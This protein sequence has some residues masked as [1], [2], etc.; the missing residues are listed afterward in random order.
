MTIIENCTLVICSK[1]LLSQLKSAFLFFIYS[2][3]YN[4]RQ[5]SPKKYNNNSNT[6]DDG[7]VLISIIEKVD[8]Y[9]LHLDLL[10]CL[11]TDVHWRLCF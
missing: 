8:L 3:K 1:S 4:Q 2:M 5:Q 10:N 7:D 11:L 9:I 6:Y